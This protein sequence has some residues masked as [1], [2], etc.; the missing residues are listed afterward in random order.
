[1]YLCRNL[2]IPMQEIS[3]KTMINIKKILLSAAFV[4]LGGISV[5]ATSKRK[6]QPLQ[7]LP[8]FIGTM[9]TAR[10]TTARTPM[11]LQLSR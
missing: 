9:F 3:I 8:R 11:F 1:M 10:F 5:L 7:L 6:N 4:A 2:Y